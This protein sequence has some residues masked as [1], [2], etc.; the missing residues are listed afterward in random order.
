[1]TPT[2]LAAEN[3]LF[4]RR[5]R[6][7][8]LSA[9]MSQQSLHDAT[10]VAISLISGVESG[11]RNISLQRAALLANAVGVPLFKLLTP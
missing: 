8:R 6:D 4:G 5:L 1:M 9:G 2:K 11:K 10:G 3:I 7:A